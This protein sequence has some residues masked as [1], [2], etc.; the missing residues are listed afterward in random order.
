MYLVMMR[1]IEIMSCFTIL[2]Y[3]EEVALK[4]EIGELVE[5]ESYYC[6]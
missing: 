1:F 4:D 3:S 2:W 5:F 6:N